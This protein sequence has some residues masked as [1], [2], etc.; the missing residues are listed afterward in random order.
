M[1]L[2]Y[3][4]MAF[5]TAAMFTS[6]I[7]D[8][9]ANKIAEYKAPTTFVL[10]QPQFSNG[11]YDLINA[12]T[13]NLTFSQPDY[14]YSA[15]CDYTVEVATDATF[16]HAATVSGTF[17]TCDIQ[18]DAN[19]FAMAVCS[20]YGWTEQADIDAALAAA[21]SGT[22]PVTIRVHSKVSSALIEGSEI[23]SN[24]ITINTIPYFALPAVELPSNF[25][26][27][28]EF[29]GWD[30][31]NCAEMVP[32]HSYPAKFWCIRYVKGADQGGQ[33]F[34]FNKKTAW[35]GSDF[36]FAGVTFKTTVPGL[37]M[38]DA[39]GNIGLNKSGWYIFAIDIA[40]EGRDFKYTLNVFPPKVYVYGPANGGN[41][42]DDDNWTL[43]VP[44][45][46]EGM[47]ESPALVATPGTEEGGCLRLCIH[48]EDTEG[49]YWGGDW[50]H[51]EFI[52]FDKKIAYRGNGGDQARVGNA[53]GAKVY[54][55]FATGYAEVK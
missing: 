35:D 53:A 24:A 15:V 8:E 19:D 47:F 18:I 9:P 29:C 41:W 45:T 16:E 30:W 48:P 14:G 3:L 12:G 6:C 37:E 2:K 1:K 52:F 23:T 21:E 4:L 7:E 26:M 33:G 49:G 5:A 22:I 34:K 11:V 46:A 28:G 13:V 36:G 17:H 38:V 51:T 20:A 55:N 31:G 54:L 50:W 39:G 40:I 42:G 43:S 32:V 27:I 10:N 25:Y 44:D